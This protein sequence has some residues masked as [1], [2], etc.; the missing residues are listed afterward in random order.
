MTRPE[1]VVVSETVR[2]AEALRRMGIA[3]VAIIVDAIE[4]T[5]GEI[6]TAMQD[7]AAIGPADILFALPRIDPPPVGLTQCAAALGKLDSDKAVL[8]RR[9]S[10]SRIA[11]G[12]R[13]EGRARLTSKAGGAPLPRGDDRGRAQHTIRDLLRTLTI[14]GGKGG[15]GKT[16]VSCALAI[17]AALD[18][19]TRAG[20]VL[21]VSTDPAPSIGDALGI[22]VANWAQRR[23]RASECHAWSARLANGRNVCVPRAAR[24]ISR[25][26][27]RVFSTRSLAAASTWRTIARLCATCWRS[28]RRESTSCMRSPHSA[29]RSKKDA[30]TRII[31]DPAPTGHLLRLLEMPALAID[32]S[33]RLMRLIMKYSEVVGLGEAAQDLVNFSRRTRALDRLLHDSNA[34]WRCARLAR[35]T[36]G[37]GRD[38]ATVSEARSDRYRD[39]WRRA[40]SCCEKRWKTHLCSD[41]SY[42]CPR[43]KSAA[44]WRCRDPRLVRTLAAARLVYFDKVRPRV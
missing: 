13:R 5:D 14:V 42:S 41:T 35:R 23:P 25:S 4:R 7:L 39:P 21:L 24:P 32:W 12:L 20:D 22:A 19:P 30:T 3:I 2:Y 27:R 29:T 26:H 9:K 36:G 44:G 11:K 37:R 33:H 17:F 40:Q 6:A 31:V 1:R 16:T 34:S 28:L 38:E 8:G 15:V 43:D 10:V 18:D